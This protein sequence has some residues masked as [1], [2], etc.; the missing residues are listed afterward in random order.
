MFGQLLSKAYIVCK[1]KYSGA[2]VYTLPLL[3]KFYKRELFVFKFVLL[4]LCAFQGVCICRDQGPSSVPLVSTVCVG[5][6]CARGFGVVLFGMLLSEW[7]KVF[8]VLEFSVACYGCYKWL[9]KAMRVSNTVVSRVFTEGRGG[10]LRLDRVMDMLQA[11]KLFK[12][13]TCANKTNSRNMQMNLTFKPFRTHR[14]MVKY[15]VPACEGFSL[16]VEVSWIIFLW[17]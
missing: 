14:H 12:Q 9:Q 11:L 5:P 7:F 6:C 10:C 4:T 15:G 17:M 13:H 3:H 1:V 8:H 2:N 16:I